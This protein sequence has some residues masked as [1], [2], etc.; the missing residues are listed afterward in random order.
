MEL[1]RHTMKRICFLIFFAAAM[2]WLF[3]HSAAVVKQ[4]QMIF[5][6]LTPFLIGFCFAF[7][8]NVLLR[9]LEQGWSK[10]MKFKYAG[11]F[12]RLAC[13]I[14]ATLLLIGVIFILIFMI[15]P[16]LKNTIASVVDQFPQY[17]QQFMQW[18]ETSIQ[19]L[20]GYGIRTPELDLNFNAIGD[21]MSSFLSAQGSFFFNKT[22]DVTSSIFSTIVNGAL[23]IVFAFYVL[24]QKERLSKNAKKIVQ[25][26]LPI[27]KA[28]HCIH[29]AQLCDKTFTKFVTGQ[30]LESCIIGCLCFLGMRIFAMP[31]ALMIS[32]MVGFT[33]LIP[34]F[35]ALI[36][37]GVGAFLILMIDPMQ[38][39]WFIVFIIV[40]QQVEGDFIYPKVVGKS[41]GLPSIWVLVAVTIGA[42]FGVLGMLLSVPICS[43]L[44][45]VGKSIINERLAKKKL[46]PLEES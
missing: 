20:Q 38:A 16:E 10:H 22:M 26:L 46:S 13:L 2:F 11:K 7:M 6:I 3:Y 40:L 42:S 24:F 28:E 34:V 39:F 12:K 33:A 21:Y 43:I 15:V 27:D 30:L 8:L 25:A 1:H 36:G 18:W 31:Y 29:L 9:P 4:L 32:T 5:A 14:L 37:T 17:R 35:G 41:V 44:Y 19:F 45:T 23:G